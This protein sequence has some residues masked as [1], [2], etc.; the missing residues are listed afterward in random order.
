MT[1]LITLK[2]TAVIKFNMIR[3]Y[4]QWAIEVIVILSPE[5]FLLIIGYSKNI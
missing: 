1:K 5:F 4:I 3:V 2:Q